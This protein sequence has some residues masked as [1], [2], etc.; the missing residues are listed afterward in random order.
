MECPLGT[1]AI[2]LTFTGVYIGQ[3]GLRKDWVAAR[4]RAIGRRAVTDIL[5][6]HDDGLRC[7]LISCSFEFEASWLQQSGWGALQLKGR[8]ARRWLAY[9][10]KVP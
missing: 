9:C 3:R 8:A 5:L 7:A 10:A 2:A 6:L 4:R 1:G